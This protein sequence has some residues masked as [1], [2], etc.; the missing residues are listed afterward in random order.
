M[1]RAEQMG[2]TNRDEE[3][4]ED[5]HKETATDTERTKTGL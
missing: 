3:S 4:G 1:N 2:T 5:K